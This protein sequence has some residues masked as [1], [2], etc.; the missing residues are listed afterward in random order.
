MLTGKMA[1]GFSPEG[2]SGGPQTVTGDMGH[3]L[4]VRDYP[5]HL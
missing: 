4:V 1:L 2:S 5:M 3:F